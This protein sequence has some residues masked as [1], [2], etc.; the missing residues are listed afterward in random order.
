MVLVTEYE[1]QSAVTERLDDA[2]G[3][4]NG[5]ADILGRE[6]EQIEGIFGSMQGYWRGKSA[7]SFGAA[8]AQCCNNIEQLVPML[9]S[10]SSKLKD[11][12]DS[13]R[14]ADT[15]STDQVDALPSD[16]L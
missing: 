11:I 15:H 12:S 10:Y 8:A 13:Y 16:L 4:I 9:L 1:D 5:S 3:V 14:A 2:A 6:L 7:D